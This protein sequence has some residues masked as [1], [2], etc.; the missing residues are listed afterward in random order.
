MN[1]IIEAESSITQ[2][3]FLKTH[4]YSLK[5]DTIIPFTKRKIHTQSSVARNTLTSSAS[6]YSFSKTLI[7]VNN[8][9]IMILPIKNLEIN[10]YHKKIY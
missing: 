6:N 4:E 7:Y 3:S 10:F 9:S 8:Y 1:V 2:L 5:L